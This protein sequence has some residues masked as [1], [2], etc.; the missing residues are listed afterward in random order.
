M[1]NQLQAP[2][3]T[4]KDWII[5]ILISAIPLVGFV[6]MFV[7]AFGSNENPNKSNFAKA[8]LIWTA[9]SVVL[10]IIF[11]STLATIFLSGGRNQFDV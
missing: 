11:Y 6:M 7:W 1:E 9:I 10:M 2:V 8:A 3:M 5:T 4:T